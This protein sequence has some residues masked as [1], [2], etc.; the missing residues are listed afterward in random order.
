VA[1]GDTLFKELVTAKHRCK[2]VVVGDTIKDQVNA[3]YV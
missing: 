3:K 1:V 2:F